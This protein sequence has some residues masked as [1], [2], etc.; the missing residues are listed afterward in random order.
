MLKCIICD[1]ETEANEI[2]YITFDKQAFIGVYRCSMRI[3]ICEDC[4]KKIKAQ[5]DSPLMPRFIDDLLIK[6]GLY[7]CLFGE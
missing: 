2:L 7:E 3:M 5:I 6:K 4:L 1:K